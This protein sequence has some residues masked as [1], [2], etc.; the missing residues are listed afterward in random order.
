MIQLGFGILLKFAAGIFSI[1]TYF[2]LVYKINHAY[3][4]YTC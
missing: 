1:N 3:F 4:V 2:M